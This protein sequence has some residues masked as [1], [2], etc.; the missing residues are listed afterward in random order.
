MALELMT[1][2]KQKIPDLAFRGWDA[3]VA[4][5]TL[6]SLGFL[7]CN[8]ILSA[9]A[10]ADVVVIANDHA[11]FRRLAVADIAA[12]MRKPALIYDLCGT[13]PRPAELPAGVSVRTFGIG[14]AGA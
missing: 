11:D 6:T 4:P 1:V 8:D 9:A 12:V 7:P 13:A 10:D 3:V 5:D 14:A 2:L